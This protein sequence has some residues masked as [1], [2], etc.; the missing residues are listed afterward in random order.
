MVFGKK[1]MFPPGKG[2]GGGCVYQKGLSVDPFPIYIYAKC[3]TNIIRVDI[4][5]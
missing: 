5:H 2:R 1:L 4:L 3:D